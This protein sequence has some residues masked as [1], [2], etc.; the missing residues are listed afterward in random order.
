MDTFLTIYLTGI[1]IFAAAID[2]RLQK[3][4]N[5]ITFPS[6]V[7]SIVYNTIYYGQ[8]GFFLS[9]GGLLCGIALLIVPYLMGGMG[10]GDA[11]LMGAVGSAIGLKGVFV[12]FL[13][14]A[15]IGGIYSLILIMIRRDHF[16]GFFSKIGTVVLNFLLF[17]KYI[18][19][20][21]KIESKNKPHL[22]YGLAIALGTGLYIALNLS[23]YELFN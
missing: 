12:A 6:M 17:R 22:C 1:L 18:P 14:T 15:I 2:L 9:T 8:T 19:E 23:G 7:I 5:Y 11:K 20:P 21:A 16:Q 10:A 13:F 3:I 4:P